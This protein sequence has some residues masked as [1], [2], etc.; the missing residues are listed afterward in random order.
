[1]SGIIGARN[2]RF[3]VY[4]DTMNTAARME[5][6]GL[7]LC[8]HTTQDVVDLAPGHSWEKLKKKIEMKGKG[9]MQTYV[10]RPSPHPIENGNDSDGVSAVYQ[11]AGVGSL[12]F[13][14]GEEE[15]VQHEESKGEEE[16]ETGGYTPVLKSI[17][18]GVSPWYLVTLDE[19][20]SK[21]TKGFGLFFKK[22]HIERAF[23]DRQARLY[24]NSTYLGHALYA[25]FLLYNLLGGYL[26]YQFQTNLCSKDA[27]P[28]FAYICLAHYGQDVYDKSQLSQDVTI[29]YSDII[30]SSLFR[31]TPTIGAVLAALILCGCLSHWFI[32][33]SKIFREKSWALLNAWV[34]YVAN[35]IISI[36]FII[37]ARLPDDTQVLWPWNISFMVLIQSTL[38]LFLTGAPFTLN[39]L[40]WIIESIVYYGL[41]LPVVLRGQ[42]VAEEKK[43]YMP[44]LA[45]HFYIKLSLFLF[46]YGVIILLGSY[47]KD[48]TSRKRFLQR[49]LMHRQK[50][51]IIRSKSMNVS[52]QR[53]FLN[54][55]LPSN[56]VA[57][58]R[59]AARQ[60]K[61]TS[62][63]FGKLQS[64]S[65]SHVGVSMLFADLV[66]FTAFSAQVD[67][68][69]VMVFLNELFQRFDK[70]CDEYNVYKVETVGDCYVATVGLVTGALACGE[71]E[72]GHSHSGKKERSTSAPV[73]SESEASVSVCN[74]R[75]MVGFAKAMLVASRTV[76]KPDLNTP[77]TM[78]IGIHTG[79]CISGIVG[80]K[81]PKLT[82]LGELVVR[83]AHLEKWGTPDCIHTS[84]E[85]ADLVPEEPWLENKNKIGKTYLLRV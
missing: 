32:H 48:I 68:F 16:G 62:S 2:F 66:G 58:L 46:W 67:P 37:L 44:I 19:V 35:L 4:G 65:K 57:E 27:D 12:H 61:L 43:E 24:R 29:Q 85:M 11:S 78:R 55:F 63:S 74:A 13:M 42:A 72:V 82:L 18:S 30:N 40:W 26:A 80:S 79:S 20:Y 6:H 28:S 33:R 71:A 41:T 21:H 39:L 52:M 10:L 84:R 59:I 22:L 76:L 54:N 17:L 83:A 8:I 50:S 23:L 25:F 14:Q 34:F 5:Q 81:R 73:V 69:K 3:T 56:A 7:P 45:T 51:Q 53:N 64:L 31:M 47:F 60:N 38:L 15:E 1:M 9:S 75:D 49:I 77:A 70:M 36:S